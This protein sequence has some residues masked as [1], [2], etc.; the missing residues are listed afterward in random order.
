M[1]SPLPIHQVTTC[2]ALQVQL[3]D[4][5]LVGVIF[6]SL[7]IDACS[8]HARV[9]VF[10]INNVCSFPPSSPLFPSHDP[11]KPKGILNVCNDECNSILVLNKF[12]HIKGRNNLYYL[13]KCSDFL[14]NNK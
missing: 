3:Y 9:L 7:F 14:L 6:F 10:C 11:H 8:V 12:I 13:I 2:R 1:P 4:G 5:D